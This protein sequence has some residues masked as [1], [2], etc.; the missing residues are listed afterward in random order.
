MKILVLGN[1]GD[2][3]SGLYIVRS[4]EDMKHD[5][6]Y[7]DTREIVTMRGIDEGQKEI[8]NTL[9]L[10]TIEPELIII[11]KGLEMTIDTIQY[12]K[13]TY[14]CPVINWFF[15]AYIE[16]KKIWENDIYLEVLKKYDYFFCSLKG[17]ADMLIDKGFT[18]VYYLP[19][20]CFP[21]LHK[22]QYMNNFQKKKYGQDITFCGTIGLSMHQ[23]RMTILK[24]II[25]EGFWI[26]IYGDVAM[27]W[28]RVPSTIKNSHKKEIAINE[29]GS[30]VAQ[31]SLINLGIDQDPE[32]TLSQSARMYR[33]M[34]AGGLYLTTYVKDLE[35]MFKINEK[36]KP[37][38]SD[39]ELVVYYDENDLIDK[40]DFLLANDN[41]RESIAKNGQKVVMEKHT[42]IQRLNK[43]LEIIK[44][45]P[46]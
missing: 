21:E 19:E 22:E 27:D 41:I 33:V 43:M 44:G 39:H 23:N 3:Q 4:L 45:K 38:T 37:I 32:L 2:M 25:E 1:M 30:I 40:L 28:K 17:V 11:L 5:V 46:K 29:K 9:K 14:K 34:C 35:T 20:G 18:N 10:V 7:I 8:K 31:T 15:D 36:N 6:Q 12:V 42:F 16:G 24:R 13:D 26:D